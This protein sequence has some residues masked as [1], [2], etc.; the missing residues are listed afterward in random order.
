M[1]MSSDFCVAVMC[2]YNILDAGS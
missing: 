2:M 1:R